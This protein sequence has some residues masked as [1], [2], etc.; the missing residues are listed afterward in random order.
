MGLIAFGTARLVPIVTRLY[1]ADSW[2]VIRAMA[3]ASAILT[4]LPIIVT[5]VSRVVLYYVL[6]IDVK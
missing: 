5:A 1:A 6:I 3:Y 2:R 4:P